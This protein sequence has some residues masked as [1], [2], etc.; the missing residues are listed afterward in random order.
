MAS[1]ANDALTDPNCTERLGG[2]HDQ[3]ACTRLTLAELPRSENSIQ[4]AETSV[5]SKKCIPCSMR[6]RLQWARDGDAILGRG[7]LGKGSRTA[8]R[9]GPQGNRM[10]TAC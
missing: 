2:D 6:I 5:Y 9:T 8:F 4:P 7:V 1:T 10:S 3:E